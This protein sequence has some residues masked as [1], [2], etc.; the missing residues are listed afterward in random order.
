[1][2]MQA[3]MN[4][5]PYQNSSAGGGGAGSGGLITQVQRGNTVSFLA[6]LPQDIKAALLSGIS[7]HPYPKFGKE[8]L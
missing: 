5:S 6:D 3:Q 2:Q 4:H 8:P 7:H 1:M